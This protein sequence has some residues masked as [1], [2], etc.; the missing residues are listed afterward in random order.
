M[1]EQFFGK[2]CVEKE[3]GKKRLISDNRHMPVWFRLI[4]APDSPCPKS[5]EEVWGYEMIWSDHPGQW[6]QNDQKFNGHFGGTYHKNVWPIFVGLNFRGQKPPI[7]MAKNMV[8]GTVSTSISSYQ[9]ILDVPKVAW[10]RRN[11]AGYGP[12]SQARDLGG[13]GWGTSYLSSTG[14]D[15]FLADVLMTFIKCVTG[16]WF[17]ATPLKNMKVNWD[18]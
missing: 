5:S 8:Y 1:L 9:W 3:T 15:V 11:S 4:S 16:G 10:G 2:H 7:S 14:N 12:C 13:L 17:L 6:I 18:D